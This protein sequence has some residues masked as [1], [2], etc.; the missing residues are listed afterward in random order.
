MSLEWQAAVD[1]AQHAAG[2][3]GVGG[4]GAESDAALTR[5]LGRI[6]DDAL[7]RQ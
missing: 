5:R 3:P 1:R 7:G 4:V 6:V 2:D